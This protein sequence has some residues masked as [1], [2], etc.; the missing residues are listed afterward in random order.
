MSTTTNTSFQTMLNQYL[1]NELLKEEFIKR[2]W[3]LQNCEMDNSWLGGQLIVPFKG[4]QASSVAF[5]G[6]TAS[7]DIAQDLYVRGSID[8][9]PE[10]WGSMIFNHTDLMRHNKVNEQN[11][12]KILPD[13]VEDFMEYMKMVVSLSFLNGP[14]FATLQ[15]N[16]N[17]NGNIT[18]DR[19]ERF[20]LNQKVY[21]YDATDG[22][23]A[24]AY[25]DTINMN[26]AVVHLVTVRGGSTNFD[27]SGFTLANGAQVY[28]DGSQTQPL[29]SLKTSLLSAANT[30]SSGAGSST[31]YGKSKASYPYLQ[32]INIDGSTATGGLAVTSTTFL[33]NLFDAFVT[34]KNRGKGMPTKAVM[35]YKLFGWAMS[36]LESQKGA[37]HIDQT[38]RKVNSYGWEEVRLFGPK[39][40]LEL[41]SIQEMDNDCVFFLD[42]RPSV[43][44]IYTNGGFRKRVSPN[45]LEYFEVRNQSGFQYI[46]DACLFG[47]FV[48]LRPSYC[49]VLCNI[50]A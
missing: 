12:L 42:M 25:V 22:L 46:V 15:A 26:T 11:F 13:T 14:F 9:Q 48:L 33:Q 6:L 30:G 5:G 3:L 18:V 38:S 24:A 50:P 49:G 28:F 7:T 1:P 23:S 32:A 29:T 21:L 39:G 36:I 45:G 8:S 37:Y 41:V 40:S 4:G 16:G 19:P 20:V 43:M 27:A 31:L 2:D 47:D 10:V 35:S 44:K 34:I 17:S